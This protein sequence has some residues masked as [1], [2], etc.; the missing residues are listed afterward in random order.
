MDFHDVP[1]GDVDGLRA[2]ASNPLLDPLQGRM[3]PSR[4]ELSRLV[5]ERILSLDPSDYLPALRISRVHLLWARAAVAPGLAADHRQ[6]RYVWLKEAF[7]RDPPPGDRRA[8]EGALHGAGRPDT[9]ARER[10]LRFVR[11]LSLATLPRELVTLSRS[12]RESEPRLPHLACIAAHR[13]VAYADWQAGGD[14]DPKVA[15]ERYSARTSL[16]ASLRATERPKDAIAIS[17]EAID[18]RRDH[19]VGWTCLIASTRDFHGAE[20]ATDIVE[21]A[22]QAV[23][24]AEAEA[25]VYFVVTAAAAYEKAGMPAE[26]AAWL[27]SAFHKNDRP[28]PSRSEVLIQARRVVDA[29][30][31]RGQDIEAE[32]LA[33]LIEEAEAAG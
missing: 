23:G 11:E 8:I 22:V 1:W 3:A 20:A 2:L 19:P 30:L 24:R 13:A 4:Y 12:L 14:T 5:N 21:P 7:I 10:A 15:A 6:Q 26:A 16:A 9:R 25:D 27:R 31:Q 28:A 32:E 29:L 17:V 18:L 33:S